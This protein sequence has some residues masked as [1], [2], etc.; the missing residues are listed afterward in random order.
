MYSVLSI[1]IPLVAVMKLNPTS[2]VR[3][4][5]MLFTETTI[6]LPFYLYNIHFRQLISNRKTVLKQWKFLI[7]F[8]TPSVVHALS[9]IIL[10]SM[11]RIMIGKM[12]G[13]R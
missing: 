3:I 10:S 2:S 6:C 5:F 8:Q 9:Y 13:K 7:L 1:I 12:A 11:D 4:S